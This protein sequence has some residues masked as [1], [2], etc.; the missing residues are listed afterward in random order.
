MEKRLYRQSIDRKEPEADPTDHSPFP[1]T[2]VERRSR[3]CETKQRGASVT[4]VR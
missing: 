2:L 3:D 4:A 1:P